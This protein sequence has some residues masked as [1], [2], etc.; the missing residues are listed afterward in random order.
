MQSI[1]EINLLPDG[2][3]DSWSEELADLMKLTRRCQNALTK[4]MKP[5][6]FNIGINLGKVAGAGAIVWIA[7]RFTD[8]HRATLDWLNEIT[9]DRFNFF[10][11]E[12]EL[13]KIGN[14]A[15]APKFNVVCKPNDWSK[16]VAEAK[17]RIDTAELSDTKQLQVEFW[18]AFRKYLEDRGSFIKATKPL[19]QHWMNIAIG[20]SGT[21]LQAFV[22]VKD[23]R[24]AVGL[25]LYDQWAK[26]YFRQLLPQ[27]GTIEVEMGVAL[28]WFE[29]PENKES[30][31]LLRRHG[32]A[33]RDRS[34]W[35]DLHEWLR[36]KL[37]RFHTV[38]APRVKDLDGESTV[39]AVAE[40]AAP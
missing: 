24:I 9:D 34:Q 27:R 8:E 39:E 12:V 13:W 16:S 30:S 21:K 5:D 31:I 33:L 11:L 1:L 29:N 25:K 35:P 32:I 6:G 4:V 3:E 40:P 7:P 28:E 2:I 14:S 36:D 38:F 20:R 23:G 26:S 37:E 10:G 15:V 17:S 19:P 18:A 22:N